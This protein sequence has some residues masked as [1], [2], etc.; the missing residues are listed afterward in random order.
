MILA[1][2]LAL[3]IVFSAVLFK[4]QYFG[5]IRVDILVF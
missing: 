5:N 2:G 3:G 1:S 4:R